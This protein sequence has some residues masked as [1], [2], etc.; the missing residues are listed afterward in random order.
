MIQ[1]QERLKGCLVGLAVGDAIG[2]TLEFSPPGSFEPIED[3]LGGGPFY[4]QPGQWTDDTSM[5]L[6]LAESL[7]L[8]QGF[9]PEDQMQRYLEWWKEGK[10]S[11][12]GKC[13]DIGATVANALHLF[14]ATG[15]P[16]CGDRDPM[17]AGNG[18]LMRLAPVPMLYHSHSD[19]YDYVAASSRTTHAAKECI[20]ACCYFSSLLKQCFQGADKRDLLVHSE[21][22]PV[23]KK[24]SKIANTDFEIKEQSQIKGTG[25]VIDC[26][27]AALWSFFTTE[28]FDDAVLKAANLGDDADTTAAVCGQIAGAYYGISAIRMEWL[29]RLF[30]LPLFLQFSDELYVL[31]KESKAHQIA[32]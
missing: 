32:K 22:Q 10:H 7:I 3:M 16:F 27:E 25:Y 31:S 2:T 24:V 13:F 4:L 14:A 5:A 15:D 26:L 18:S 12:T 17:A 23:T 20:D 21:Y 8:K 11:S 28:T 29:D 19:L 1:L 30:N 6:C 9:D